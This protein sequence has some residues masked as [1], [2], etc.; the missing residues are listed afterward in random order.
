MDTG[1]EDQTQGGAHTET[2]PIR[3]RRKPRWLDEFVGLSIKD[4]D[5]DDM[6]TYALN[7]VHDEPR[8]YRNAIASV[9]SSS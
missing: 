5:F 7:V 1:T 8:D 2:R 6:A 9:D 3:E 4:I